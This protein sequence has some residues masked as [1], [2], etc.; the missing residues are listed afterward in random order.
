[1][2]TQKDFSD[3]T[4]SGVSDQNIK[5]SSTKLEVDKSDSGMEEESSFQETTGLL[6]ESDEEDEMFSRKRVRGKKQMIIDDDD[7]EES[8]GEKGEKST[9]LPDSGL[10]QKSALVEVNDEDKDKAEVNQTGDAE[11][12]EDNENADEDEDDDGPLQLQFNDKDVF[13]AESSDE[14]LQESPIHGA[15]NEN[16][17]KTE[18]DDKSDAEEQE[19][20]EEK[21]ENDE[22][23]DEDELDPEL[24]KQLKKFKGASKSA[25][26]RAKYSRK[27][28]PTADK[29]LEIYSESQRLKRDSRVNLPYYEPEEKSLDDFL[30]RASKKRQEYATLK[31]A[32]DFQKAQIIHEKLSVSPPKMIPSRRPSR[33]SAVASGHSSQDPQN[34]PSSQPPPSTEALHDSGLVSQE[35]NLS[36][37]L[38]TSQSSTVVL[39]SSQDPEPNT[40]FLS[41]ADENDDELPDPREKL[42]KGSYVCKSPINS[43]IVSS[44]LEGG[45]TESN[46]GLSQ[47]IDCENT[48]DPAK[49]Q[50]QSESFSMEKQTQEDSESVPSLQKDPSL[51]LFSSQSVMEKDA[52]LVCA[53]SLDPEIRPEVSLQSESS[54]PAS[55]ATIVCETPLSTQSTQHSTLSVTTSAGHSQ[56]EITQSDTLVM[57]ECENIPQSESTT[58]A[59]QLELGKAQT[60]ASPEQKKKSIMDKLQCKGLSLPPLPKLSGTPSD[61]ICLDEEPEDIETTPKNPGVLRLMD[62]LARHSQKKLPKKA[63]DVD[64]S[65]VEKESVQGQQELKLKSVTYHVQPEEEVM[66]SDRAPGSK[67]TLL[68]QKLSVDMRKKREEARQKRIELYN[69]E[70]EEGFERAED[71]VEEEEEEAEM[72][73]GEEED[74]EED[75]ERELGLGD[76]D[77]DSDDDGKDY[78]PLLDTEAREDDDED[79]DD[80]SA[81]NFN[82]DSNDFHL[83][84]EVSDEEDDDDDKESKGSD[85]H[86]DKE[87]E[88]E[89][90]SLRKKKRRSTAVVSDDEEDENESEKSA[91]TEVKKDEKS[92]DEDHATSQSQWLNEMTPLSKH[93]QDTQPQG[94]AKFRRRSSCSPDL[95]ASTSVAEEEEASS[96]PNVHNESSYSQGY[97]NLHSQLLDADGYLKVAQTQ[98]PAKSRIALLAQNSSDGI[99]GF[100]FGM[101][102]GQIF[103]GAT[104]QVNRNKEENEDENMRELMGLC[105][106]KFKAS[107]DDEESLP[108]SQMRS[109]LTQSF[110]ARNLFDDDDDDA[111][112]P[113]RILSQDENAQDFQ[114][115]KQKSVL[116]DSDDDEDKENKK[117]GGTDT[118]EEN[119]DDV[120]EDTPKFTGFKDKN[121]GIRQEFLD[122]EAELSGSEFDSDENLD[123]AEEDDILEEEEGDRDLAGV[124]ESKL[125]D[126]VG[127]LHMKQLQDDDDR[128]IMRYKE[129]YLQ[130]GDLYT[131][132]RGRRR[133]FRWKDIGESSQQ[134][135]FSNASDE[136]PADDEPEETNWRKDRFERDKFLEESENMGNNEDSQLVKLGQGFLQKKDSFSLPSQEFGTPL[137]KSTSNDK[138]L[139]PPKKG[140]FLSRSK[141]A[142]SKIAKI[143]KVA[144]GGNV[145]NS[146]GFVFQTVEGKETEE[147][148]PPDNNPMQPPKR[149]AHMPSQAQQAAKKQKLSIDTK[150]SQEKPAVKRK[151]SILHLL[152]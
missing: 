146:R 17:S 74:S 104:S 119:D 27:A 149:K 11:M 107:E 72:T 29:M 45:I 26:E 14:D 101:S 129:M 105:S 113:F 16:S 126:Q 71:E 116:S 145:K 49:A 13:D 88:V 93:L 84:F 33:R 100:G 134:D 82:E 75:E 81:S 22:G 123:L 132:G 21:S 24:L 148:D 28:K 41:N 54:E 96:G 152:D 44:L 147:Q 114:S 143:A 30:A 142:L 56:A 102:I 34:T 58:K 122:V 53:Q 32:N 47:Q 150:P 78:N 63:Y 99:G 15:V 79:D 7:D 48:E 125:R 136:E 4:E 68:K 117:Y 59:L 12:K 51:D 9:E 6:E 133:N 76:Y 130:D 121:K 108:S 73:D 8:D 69:M 1:M 43:N 64:I 40:V 95:Y 77:A 106:G 111:Y 86:D 55:L 50:D 70:N 19:N 140:S 87:D 57:A 65:I 85:E 80:A 10:E 110:E 138:K 92:L 5:K 144:L 60:E 39:Q 128:E 118:D 109:K 83:N 124:S 52:E 90:T 127:K 151:N 94:Q 2:I 135:M 35:A 67:L 61:V 91:G 62:R 3:E 36:Q 141:D 89:L 66:Q 38:Q 20:N 97:D 139:P 23:F 31:R 112:D 42:I 103:G 120:T 25:K 46:K 98:K 137:E 131:D 115:L 18:Q 37:P